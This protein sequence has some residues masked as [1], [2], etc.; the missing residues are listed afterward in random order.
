MRICIEFD[1]V[2]FKIEKKN[3]ESNGGREDLYFQW[4]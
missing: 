2:Q 4:S 1:I 3:T